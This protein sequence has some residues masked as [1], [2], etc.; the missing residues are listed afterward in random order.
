[1][2][3]DILGLGCVAVDET[4][5]VEQFP[6]EDSKARIVCRAGAVGG[7]AGTALLAAAKLGAVCAYAGTLGDDPASQLVVDTFQQAGIGTSLIRREEGARPIRCTIVASQATGSRTVLYDLQGARPAAADWPQGDAIRGAKLLLVDQFGREWIIPAAKIARAAAVPVVLDLEHADTADDYVDFLKH[8]NHIIL[9]GDLAARITGQARPSE[10][11]SR[12]WQSGH[13]AI[14]LTAGA[15]GLWYRTAADSQPQ[16]F[17]AYAVQARDTTGCG[18]VFRGAYAAAL[19][20]GEAIVDC[21]RFGAAAAALRAAATSPDE[22]LPTRESVLKLIAT[23][24][25]MV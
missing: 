14:V 16:H 19:L 24:C 20:R 22:R 11:L 21:I 1:M 23:G 2:P 12:L 8:A 25:A 9:T 17:P 6:A 10:A 15:A 5:T 18:D 4:L 13:E 3:Y 7:S